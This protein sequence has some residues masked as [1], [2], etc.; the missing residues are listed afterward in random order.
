MKIKLTAKT[1][2]GSQILRQHGPPTRVIR[3]AE[4]LPIGPGMWYLFGWA[5]GYSRWVKSTNDPIFEIT[6]W[7]V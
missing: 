3:E 5:D 6:H 7:K 1:A 4:N 2:K